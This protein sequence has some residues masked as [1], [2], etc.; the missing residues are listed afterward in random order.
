MFAELI[1][2]LFCNLEVDTA[3]FG[4][5]HGLDF[6]QTFAR[7]LD[8]LAPLAADGL[9]RL[10]PGKV[11]ITPIGQLLLRNVASVFDAWLPGEAVRQHSTAV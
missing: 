3:G 7:E 6:D 4:R 11:T 1:M 5:I 2:Q 9:V 10:A 8:T